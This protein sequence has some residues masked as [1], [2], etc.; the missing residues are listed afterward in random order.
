MT[1]E[2]R[3]PDRISRTVRR[4]HLAPR[5]RVLDLRTV[6]ST[7][8]NGVTGALPDTRQLTIATARSA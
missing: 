2:Q 5:Q 3:Q 7:T 4:G 1:I 6:F 8:V